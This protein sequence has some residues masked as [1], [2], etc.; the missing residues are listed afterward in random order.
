[1]QSLIFSTMASLSATPVD[2]IQEL[3]QRLGD[4]EFSIQPVVWRSGV[5][6]AFVRI[7]LDVTNPD[8]RVRPT[9]L[10]LPGRLFFHG[11]TSRAWPLRCC[12]QA[13]RWNVPIWLACFGSNENN[14]ILGE[15]DL[16]KA[17]LEEIKSVVG[18]T[19]GQQSEV[20]VE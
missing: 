12:W 3:E 4:Q 10:P 2:M 9:L 16:G 14:V 18:E 7:E 5:Y 11:S 8:L 13:V 17:L 19:E 20:G 15:T 1:M 6:E